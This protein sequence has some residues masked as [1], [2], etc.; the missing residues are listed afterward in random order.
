MS[1]DASEQLDDALCAENDVFAG[2][3]AKGAIAAT[4]VIEVEPD[5]FDE[6]RRRKCAATGS[7]QQYKQ[8]RVLKR[9]EDVAVLRSPDAPAD[10]EP[11][12]GTLKAV[13]AWARRH[14]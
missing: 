6:L 10:E 1:L 2:W 13:A 14:A 3:R 4:R 9:P 12:P 5:A 11:P 8:P 7:S